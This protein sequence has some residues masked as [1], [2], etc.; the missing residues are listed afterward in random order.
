MYDL[1]YVNYFKVV[2][3]YCFIFF[4]V[5]LCD[6]QYFGERVALLLKYIL[7]QQYYQNVFS[8]T[9]TPH[10]KFES[11]ENLAVES[12]TLLSHTMKHYGCKDSEIL[13][14]G[15]SCPKD[16]RSRRYVSWNTVDVIFCSPGLHVV[17]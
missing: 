17:L 10:C 9:V 14:L 16:Q 15:M 13:L 4:Y 7:S 3:V 12:Q 5:N 2:I 11:S 8:D 6:L 1:Q